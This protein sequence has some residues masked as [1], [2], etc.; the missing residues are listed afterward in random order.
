MGQRA[1]REAV[2]Q[3]TEHLPLAG[4]QFPLPPGASCD[5]TVDRPIERA[6]NLERRY[7]RPRVTDGRLHRSRFLQR[8]AAIET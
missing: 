5:G 8:I 6:L 4:Q 3:F 1:G 7:R 2:A